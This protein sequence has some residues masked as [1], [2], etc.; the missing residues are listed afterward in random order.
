[1]SLV[2]HSI[3]LDIKTPR[4]V[5]PIQLFTDNLSAY[6]II[7]AVTENGRR[8]NL[9]DY[10]SFEM[11]IEGR[12]TNLTG[13]MTVDNRAKFSLSG[14]SIPDDWSVCSVVLSDGNEAVETQVFQIY[15]K[16]NVPVQVDGSAVTALSQQQLLSLVGLYD[17]MIIG[18]ANASAISRF[19]DSGTTGLNVNNLEQL[20]Y[21]DILKLQNTLQITSIADD[22]DR[23]GGG[24]RVANGV[25]H[26][27]P[28]ISDV[29][30][31]GSTSVSNG[32]AS[33]SSNDVV[34]RISVRRANSTESSGYTGS[35]IGLAQYDGTH[36]TEYQI[37]LDTGIDKVSLNGIDVS[38]TVDNTTNKKTANINAVAG[39]T[40]RNN[41][42]NTNIDGNATNPRLT[43]E[44]G[45]GIALSPNA[46]TGKITVAFDANN[47]NVTWPVDKLGLPASYNQG[48]VLIAYNGSL[49]LKPLSEALGIEIGEDGVSIVTNINQSFD[50]SD[51]NTVTTVADSDTLP[52][53]HGSNGTKITW[54]NLMTQFAQTHRN[55]YITKTITA[56]DWGSSDTAT[57]TLTAQDLS[58]HNLTTAQVVDAQGIYHTH[59]HIHPEPDSVYTLANY[60]IYCQSV[61]ASNG[62]PAF[63]FKRNTTITRMPSVNITIEVRIG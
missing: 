7:V 5:Q 33:I 34:S 46:S 14:V 12:A 61:A 8:V 40:V 58:D 11:K 9:S 44:A 60:G 18:G 45:T 31:N 4:S 32:L 23:T 26:I 36:P 51:F 41:N 19:T 27:T 56:S 13:S 59:A 39:I 54:A 43:I 53:L 55:E 22:A 25:L 10:S 21:N 37:A 63:T 42:T 62:L 15:K 35:N 57:I 2:E 30:L 47:G 29:Q 49:Q 17:T 1:M 38:T 48:D 3:T 16:V 20:T 6:S 28:K 24:S 50:F 52:F